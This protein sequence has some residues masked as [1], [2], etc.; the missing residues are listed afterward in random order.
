M[1]MMIYFDVKMLSNDTNSDD[2]SH[3]HEI[4]CLAM[5]ILPIYVF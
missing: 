1:H 4:D 3:D 2:D 5:I